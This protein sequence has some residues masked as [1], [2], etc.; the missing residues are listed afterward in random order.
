VS[1]T[2]TRGYKQKVEPAAKEQIKESKKI[3]DFKRKMTAVNIIQINGFQNVAIHTFNSIYKSKEELI[4]LKKD[5]FKF[6]ILNSEFV[7]LP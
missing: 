2:L 1:N 4:E 3:Y 5:D 6:L 7:D